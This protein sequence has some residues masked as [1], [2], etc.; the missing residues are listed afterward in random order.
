MYQAE[1]RI[2]YPSTSFAESVKGALSPDD[3]AASGSVEVSST[4]SGK[5]LTVQVMGANRF[6]TLHATLQDI[7]RCIHAAEASLMKL[8][9]AGS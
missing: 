7:F 5:I 2:R 1:I 4:V 8:G 6:E 9:S 3:K